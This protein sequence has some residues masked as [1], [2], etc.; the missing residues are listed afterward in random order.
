M[1]P[2]DKQRMYYTHT[3]NLFLHDA[4]VNL[5]TLLRFPQSVLLKKFFL[6]LNFFSL[7]PMATIH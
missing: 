1:V 7:L 4:S 5:L 6:V 3:H 2:F